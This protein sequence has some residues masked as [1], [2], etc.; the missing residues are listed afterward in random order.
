[1]CWEAEING[2]I[3]QSQGTHLQNAQ[4]MAL[5]KHFRIHQPWSWKRDSVQ[6]ATIFIYWILHWARGTNDKLET[7]YWNSC[8]WEKN[9]IKLIKI[10]QSYKLLIGNY[11]T[12]CNSTTIH[13]C[14][15]SINY[16]KGIYQ[17][18]DTSIS[19]NQTEKSLQYSPHTPTRWPNNLHEN[20]GNQLQSWTSRL[21]N[22]VGN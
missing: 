15:A 12:S 14:Q 13:H 3:D 7:A 21:W 16:M 17:M 4:H 9:E 20:K 19:K 22:Q 10:E 2:N 8:R 1:M 5:M 11:S 6:T 18:L